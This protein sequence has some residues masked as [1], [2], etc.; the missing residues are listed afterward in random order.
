MVSVSPE[1]YLLA[2]HLTKSA[3][4]PGDKSAA[5]MTAATYDRYLIYTDGYQK[6]GTQ[7]VNDETTG[8]EVWAS[9]DPKTSDEKK[10]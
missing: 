10:N 3:Y 1:I 2:H 9:I 5:Y 4:E 8:E 6:Y 7:R